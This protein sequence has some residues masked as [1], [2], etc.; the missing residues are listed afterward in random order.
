MPLLHASE[1]S[2]PQL[3]I[4]EHQ[5]A[6]LQSKTEF[7]EVY[8]HTMASHENKHDEHKGLIL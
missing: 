4:N 5:S 1:S 6:C 2:I 8:I 7:A 3:L